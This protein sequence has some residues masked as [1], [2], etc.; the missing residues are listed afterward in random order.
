[1]KLFELYATLGLDTSRFEEGINSAK[2]KIKNINVAAYQK[3]VVPVINEITGRISSGVTKVASVAGQAAISIGKTA[4]AVASSIESAMT[5]AVTVAGTATVAAVTAASKAGIDYNAEMEKYQTAFTSILGSEE[6]AAEV[7]EQIRQDA[8]TTPF[9]VK[10]LTQGIQMLTSTGISAESART[11]VLALGDAIAATGGGSDEMS[12]MIQNLQ[13]IKNAGTASGADIKQFAYAG[14]DIYGIM[15]EYYGKTTEEVKDMKISYDDLSNALVKAASKG[16][17][18]YNAMYNQSKTYNGQ[19]SNLKDNLEMLNGT[20][21]EGIFETFRDKLLPTA[22]SWVDRLQAA[23]D[24]SAGGMD[25]FVS[26]I[27]EASKISVEFAES[28]TANIPAALAKFQDFVDEIS[29]A[30]MEAI[31]A[32]TNAGKA[33]F[34]AIRKGFSSSLPKI[35]SVA[36][37]IGPAIV[38]GIAEFK[39]DMLSAGISIL[40]GIAEGISANKG[41]LTDSI[42][43][44]VNTLCTSITDN[45]GVIATAAGDIVVA[46][47][48][49]LAQNKEEIQEATTTLINALVDCVLDNIGPILAAGAEIGLALLNGIFESLSLLP[50]KLLD[51]LFGTEL[52]EAME[53]AEW[54]KYSNKKE[55]EA[56]QREQE[57]REYVAA[58]AD[59]PE[60]NALLV[61]SGNGYLLDG[62]NQPKGTKEVAK[63]TE[64]TAKANDTLATSLQKV[65]TEYILKLMRENENGQAL[66]ANYA[67]TINQA[68]AEAQR[69]SALGQTATAAAEAGSEMEAMSQ[70]AEEAGQAGEEAETAIEDAL[71][72]DG[73]GIS[74]LAADATSSLQSLEAQAIATAEAVQAA[75]AAESSITVTNTSKPTGATAGGSGGTPL[76]T[77]FGDTYNPLASLTRHAT[78]L[79]TV[80]FDGYLAMLH[81]GE[82]IL[83]RREADAYRSGREEKTK[84]VTIVQNIQS[85]PLRPSELAAQTRHAFNSLR[86]S[87]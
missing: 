68:N 49:G 4:A 14:V 40:G 22:S 29:P 34:E 48:E 27:K 76:V 20:L 52:S 79:P 74:G 63:E 42:A 67:A 80:P 8:A 53:N 85:V 84:D 62:T 38:T 44:I 71:N 28:V 43:D 2:Q 83:T 17:R 69:S 9:D 10:G 56:E 21:T 73:E 30:V 32:V 60:F 78:G 66:A 54:F 12:R 24:G 3:Q 86:F 47:C 26:A 77:A 45:A 64:K 35:R 11:T 23:V 5:K 18:F 65:D 31:P 7:M 6:K 51:A 25:V 70:K 16:G 57:N 15:A 75:L 19:L 58:H 36:K 72:P 61:A 50:A 82:A 37:E 55:H 33:V 41:D 13:Q 87:V 46:L 59:D 81:R 39:G 1:M